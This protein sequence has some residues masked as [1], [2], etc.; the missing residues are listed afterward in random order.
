MGLPSSDLSSLV[1]FV[2]H[3]DE[4]ERLGYRDAFMR[5][6]TDVIT[7]IAAED[8]IPSSPESSIENPEK[9]KLRPLNSFMAYR[10]KHEKSS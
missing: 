9:K 8:Q 10:S 3:S 6:T 2:R 5:Q 4:A 7:A 1:N